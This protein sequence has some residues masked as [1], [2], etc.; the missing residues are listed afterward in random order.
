MDK[1]SLLH[2]FYPFPTQ[3]AGRVVLQ[4]LS[5]TVSAKYVRALWYYTSL[6]KFV[7]LVRH[8]KVSFAIHAISC[9]VFHSRIV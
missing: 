2:Y 4:P 5:N 8:S 1:I 3:G 7:D 6:V 9:F